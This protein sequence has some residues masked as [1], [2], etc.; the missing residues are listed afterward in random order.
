MSFSELAD[1]TEEELAAL[2]PA[3]LELYETLMLD[4][5]PVEWEL[6]AR[7]QAAEDKS[8]DVDELLYGGAAGGGKTEWL[9]WH[10]YKLC[11]EQPGH[12]VLMLRRTL[13]DLEKSVVD[14]SLERFS[15]EHAMYLVGK[16]EWRFKNGSK[17][18]L[19]YC[20]EETDVRQYLSREYDLIVFEEL[21]DFTQRQY[22]MIVSRCRTRQDKR[23][24]G[25]RPHI[26]SATNPGGVGHTWVKN[27]F[28]LRTDYGAKIGT[29]IVKVGSARRE[30]R[31]A[32]VPARVS[33]NPSIDQEYVFNLATLDD[34]R[35]RQ[36][37]DGDWD[38]FEGQYFTEFDRDVHVVEPFAIPESWTRIRGYDY[39]F[40]AP[41]C[42]LWA[43]IDWD[44]NVYVYREAYSGYV[45]GQGHVQV[46]SLTATEQGKNIVARSVYDTDGDRAGEPERI[47]YTVADPSIFSKT[48]TGVSIATMLR[49]EGL[50]TKKAMNA[51]IDGWNRVRDFLRGTPDN[52]HPHIRIFPAC[53]HLIRTIPEQ[54]HD[55]GTSANPEDLDTD[56]EDHAVDAL[57]YLLMSRPRKPRRPEERKRPD[58]AFGD[59][60]EVLRDRKRGQNH[61]VLGKNW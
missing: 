21:T 1:L 3:D 58:V 10:A 54:M 29:Y 27:H 8:H 46:R 40:A 45:D 57:R 13:P 22:R 6:H 52:G 48:G 51:R 37:L 28:V 53:E 32:F 16:R 2:D 7:Q 42:C 35:R 17:I 14:R 36:L 24:R 12:T 25:I 20:Q 59:I 56:L 4:D 18:V 34:T 9:L 50:I 61:D 41:Y 43:A 23:N 60:D 30:R 26:I 49:S 33:D 31:I 44:G 47:A 19:G 15:P 39:G 11:V 5:R 38:T 55:T